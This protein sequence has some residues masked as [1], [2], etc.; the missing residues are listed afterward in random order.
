MDTQVL[1]DRRRIRRPGNVRYRRLD[2]QAIGVGLVLS[3]LAWPK[4]T[5]AVCRSPVLFETRR[6]FVRR[7]ERV[8]TLSQR[9]PNKEVRRPSTRLQF[10]DSLRA[11]TCGVPLLP[12]PHPH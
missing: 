10:S 3:I 6:A 2:K 9:A 5:Q 11:Q 7:N 12:E 4:S 1:I 8:S